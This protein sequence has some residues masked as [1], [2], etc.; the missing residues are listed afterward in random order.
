MEKNKTKQNKIIF[1]G[2]QDTTGYQAGPACQAL[3]SKNTKTL[4]ENGL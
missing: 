2:H 3:R 4:E 1:L